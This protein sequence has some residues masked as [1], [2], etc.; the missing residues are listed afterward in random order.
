MCH[1][2]LLLTIDYWLLT[3]TIHCNQSTMGSF[4][5]E[6]GR[7]TVLPSNRYKWNIQDDDDDDDDYDDDDDDDDDPDFAW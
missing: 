5:N 3:K 7:H 1:Y 4:L 2:R 6:G